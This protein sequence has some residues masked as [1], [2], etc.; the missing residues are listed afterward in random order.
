MKHLWFRT[1][2]SLVFAA[3]GQLQDSLFRLCDSWNELFP[4][5]LKRNVVLPAARELPP[6][7]ITVEQ[8][9]VG[10]S[11]VVVPEAMLLDHSQT[12]RFKIR[13]RWNRNL[14]L[15][16]DLV[17]D[18]GL[19][20]G[21]DVHAILGQTFLGSRKQ[22]HKNELRFSGNSRD[23]FYIQGQCGIVNGQVGN[24]RARRLLKWSGG[25]QHNKPCP[26][27]E[28]V[29][30]PL[31]GSCELVQTVWAGHR[32]DLSKLC[33]DHCCANS[34]EL[35]FEIAKAILPPSL[36]DR[37][38]AEHRISLPGQVPKLRPG[39]SKGTGEHGLEVSRPL[40][41]YH[42]G[43]TGEQDNIIPGQ[44]KTTL[45]SDGGCEAEHQEA[46]STEL[47]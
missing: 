40:Q 15:P 43:A 38:L 42:V 25:D 22:V 18:V 19:G 10:R 45:C 4:F 2:V 39:S 31:I 21:L 20:L 46:K 14:Q 3:I 35:I 6:G 34:T 26:F 37:A 16:R 24:Q 7:V 12:Q 27:L 44:R 29:D 28:S 41:T 47:R 5:F 33:D 9:P 1:A 17:S 32:F 8:L 11:P 30:Q 36:D 23:R 13:F